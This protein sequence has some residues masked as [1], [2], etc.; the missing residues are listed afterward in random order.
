MLD[1]PEQILR[2]IQSRFSEIYRDF[3]SM[4]S[5]NIGVDENSV[6]QYNYI[7]YEKWK[8]D[9]TI[10][11]YTRYMEYFKKTVEELAR[12][13]NESIEGKTTLSEYIED[14]TYVSA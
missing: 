8:T 6:L 4:T 11:E 5:L 3:E 2:K 7:A 10:K 12:N 1:E 14:Y 13:G 9:S